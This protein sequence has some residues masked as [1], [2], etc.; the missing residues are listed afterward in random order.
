MSELAIY[1]QN[2]NALCKFNT[3]INID[4]G[5]SNKGTCECEWI[6]QREWIS[7]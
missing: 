2:K 5:G 6:H 1:L 4:F 7:L 3:C